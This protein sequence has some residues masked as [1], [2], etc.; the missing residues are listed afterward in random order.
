MESND[1]DIWRTIPPEEKLE[2]L[3]RA[4][5]HGVQ[6][7][8]VLVIMG[9]TIAVALQ[10]PWIFWC[11]LILIP[12]IFQFSSGK[13]W[14]GIRPRLML[15]FLAARSAARRYAFTNRA[16]DLGLQV[17]L[18]GEMSRI[19]DA[20]PRTAAL[21]AA[22]DSNSQAAVWIA[23]FNDT[24]VLMSERSGGAKLEFATPINDRLSVEARSPKGDN[25]PY[26]NNS[27]VILTYFDRHA[28]EQRQ[29]QLTSRYPAALA[30]FEKRLQS[31]IERLRPFLIEGAGEIGEKESDDDIF[32][33]RPI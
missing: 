5:S 30:V 6:S 28:N 27:A 33:Q 7:V 14:R 29:L 11:A 20:D 3:A 31:S 26:H 21:E 4:Q 2:C 32:R 8:A 18:R 9:G 23:L 24:I 17:I 25:S 19:S 15:E 12:F 13:A 22:A 1:L 10:L 16:R